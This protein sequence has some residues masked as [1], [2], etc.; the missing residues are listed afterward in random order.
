MGLGKVRKPEGADSR[1]ERGGAG[2][3]HKDLIDSAGF[4]LSQPRPE[5]RDV[6]LFHPPPLQARDRS[7]ESQVR[8]GTS[9]SSAA[10]NSAPATARGRR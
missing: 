8:V 2:H 3:L 1:C 4:C 9:G 6:W 5:A 7:Q 10:A